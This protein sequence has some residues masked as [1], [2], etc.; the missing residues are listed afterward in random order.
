[1]QSQAN[2]SFLHASPEDLLGS[3]AALFQAASFPDALPVGNQHVPVEYA[4]APGEAH[5]GVTLRLTLPLA[6]VLEPGQL[7]WRIPALREER[8]ADLLR[9]LPKALRRPLMP[10][11]AT[12]RAMAAALNP[13]AG[14]FLPA[15]TEYVRRVHGVEIPM[16]LWPVDALPAHLR[17]RY[18][19]I[20]REQKVLAMGRDLLLLR[21]EAEQRETP[22]EVVAWQRAA[23]RWERYGLTAWDWTDLPESIPVNEVAGF[24]L[25]AYPGLVVE[26][27]QVHLQLFRKK[28]EALAASRG[29]IARLAELH[30]RRELAWLHK[31]LRG[32]EPLKPL[33]VT[34]GSGEELLATAWEHLCRHLLP[35]TGFFPLTRAAFD[36]YVARA[37]ENMTGLGVRLI[38]RVQA[39]LVRRQEALM[40][41]RPLGDMR[42]QIDSLVPPRFLSSISFERM[43]QLPRYLQALIVRADRAALNRVKDLEKWSRVAPFVRAYH[44]LARRPEGPGGWWAELDE[45]RWLIEEYKV[46]CFAQELGTAVSVSPKRLE[47]ALAGLRQTSPV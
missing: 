37:R 16:N 6:T 1:M 21:T 4:Y 32:L 26:E 19:I 24:P 13:E 15:M 30:M 43:A 46:S 17:P 28:E 27:E 11:P 3:H 10:L 7:E 9:R 34:L 36:A 2:P 35:A 8:I 41:P 39:V 25:L 29:G 31:E 47:A 38:E 42:A 44:E 33:Y 12:A 18:E 45:F 20:G 40:H 22:V 23:H 14:P 5:D